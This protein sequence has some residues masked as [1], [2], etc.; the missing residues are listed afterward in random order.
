M[1]SLSFEI[2]GVPAGSAA[3]ADSF[4]LRLRGLLGR[5]AKDLGGLLITP[6]DQVHC[7]FMKEAI[8]VVYLDR[9]GQVLRID[10][11][12]KPW[13]FGPLVK[14]AK[15]VLELPE[16]RAKELNITQ[17]SRLVFHI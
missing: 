6:C 5:S 16:G 3:L 15:K 4:F 10:P 7:C 11:A 1:K 9:E 2:N 8:D 12:M 13:S 14:G 17:G